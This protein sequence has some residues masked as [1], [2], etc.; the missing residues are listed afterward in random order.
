MKSDD[1]K[2]EKNIVDKAKDKRAK[3]HMQVIFFSFYQTRS[4]TVLQDV[5]QVLPGCFD[6]TA[7][8]EGFDKLL[9]IFA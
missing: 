8:L 4:S 6:T 1:N 9:F 5:D 2:I 7:I 3:F